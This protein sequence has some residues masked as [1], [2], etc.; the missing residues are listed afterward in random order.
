MGLPGVARAT[1]AHWQAQRRRCLAG[2]P[3]APLPAARGPGPWRW[4][5]LSD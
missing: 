1:G 2:R 4:Q 3:G 5:Q